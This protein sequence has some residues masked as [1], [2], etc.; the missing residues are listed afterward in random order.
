KIRIDTDPVEMIRAQALEY[1]SAE[2][3]AF[4]TETLFVGFC[5]CI[6]EYAKR[7]KADIRFPC[8]RQT[9]AK[10]AEKVN[11]LRNLIELQLLIQDARL[12]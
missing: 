8:P 10:V 3:L 11:R 2:N 9:A 4:G 7:L 5:T 12:A 1:R 6:V